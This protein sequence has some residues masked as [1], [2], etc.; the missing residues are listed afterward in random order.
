MSI[1]AETAGTVNSALAPE[2][3]RHEARIK[4]L[5]L[6]DPYKP[7]EVVLSTGVRIVAPRQFSL[8]IGEKTMAALYRPKGMGTTFPKSLIVEVNVLGST[9]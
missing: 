2:V 8:A 7:F 4:Q 5:L 6:A 9:Q 1:T 3:Q